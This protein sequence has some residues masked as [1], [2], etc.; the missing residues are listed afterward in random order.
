MTEAQIYEALAEIFRDVFLRDDIAL[1]PALSAD[2]VDDWDSFK[3]IEIVIAAEEHFGVKFKTREMDD[4][5]NVGALV[6][7]IASK[8]VS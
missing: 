8:K 4:L 7:L 3:Q 1:T 5:P 2:D 6:Q